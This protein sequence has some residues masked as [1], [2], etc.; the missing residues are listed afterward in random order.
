[1]NHFQRRKGELC[2]EDVPLS[3]LAEEVG[4]PAYVYS[5]ATLLRHARVFRSALRGLDV[6]ACF[7]V[8]SDSA[9]FSSGVGL[10]CTAGTDHS[11]LGSSCR[12]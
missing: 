10:V 8:K 11:E 2:C 7:A 12:R 3:R 5:K 1:M 6:L 9:A 4:T